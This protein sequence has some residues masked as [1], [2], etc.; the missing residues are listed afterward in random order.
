MTEEMRHELKSLFGKDTTAL[1]K[2]MQFILKASLGHLY[3]DCYTGPYLNMFEFKRK[4]NLDMSAYL[5]YKSDYY[6]RNPGTKEAEIASRKARKEKLDRAFRVIYGIAK[7][8][9][10]FIEW[11]G[12]GAACEPDRWTVYR[13]HEAVLKVQL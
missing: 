13:N 8:N 9:H 12:T 3:D 4:Y 7:R 5:A 10:V 11:Y 2:E 6:D 1:C